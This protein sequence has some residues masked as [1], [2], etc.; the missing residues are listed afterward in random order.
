LCQS[1][2]VTLDG[3]EGLQALAYLKLRKIDDPKGNFLGRHRDKVL[4]L[5]G[6]PNREHAGILEYHSTRGEINVNVKF[7]CDARR[8]YQ[9][10]ALRVH[11][12]K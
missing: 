6:M 11:W 5:F 12:S 9:C 3:G 4:A 1:K 2:A 8:G 10:T 7:A